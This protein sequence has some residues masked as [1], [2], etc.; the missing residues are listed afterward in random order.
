MSKAMEPGE[1]KRSILCRVSSTPHIC[2]WT[3]ASII[4]STRELALQPVSTLISDHPWHLIQGRKINPGL[5]CLEFA[6]FE[7]IL[8]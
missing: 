6:S 7:K 5:R 2:V 8:R 4:D 3:V 1:M